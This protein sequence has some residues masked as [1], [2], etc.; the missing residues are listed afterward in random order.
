[1]AISDSTASKHWGIFGQ[2]NYCATMASIR[3]GSTNT[4]LLGE[5]QRFTSTSSA[6]NLPIVDISHDGWAVGGDATL[7]SRR[8]LI[9]R[10]SP[11]GR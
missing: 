11:P 1:M 8:P 7:F 6:T 2:V 10:P 5:L 9:Q 4:F 3:D